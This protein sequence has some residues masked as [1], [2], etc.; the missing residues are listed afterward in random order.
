VWQAVSG[1]FTSYFEQHAPL[2]VIVWLLGVLVLTLRLLG[3]LAYVQRLRHHQ[4]RPVEAEWLQRTQRIAAQIWLVRPV[5]VLESA[6][7][8]VP[9]AIGYFKPLILLPVGTFTGLSPQ[10][11]EAVLAHE[12]AHL[13]RNDYWVNIGQSVVE[14]LFF[15]HPAAWWMSGVVRQEREHCCDDIA[16]QTCGDN[17]TFAQALTRLETLQTAPVLA[18][19]ANGGSLLVRI[20]RLLNQSPQKPGFTDGLLVAGVLLLCLVTVSASAFMNLNQRKSFQHT[21]VSDTADGIETVYAT[22]TDSTKAVREI[23]IVKDT[24]GRITEVR[25]DGKKLNDAEMKKY[26]PVIAQKLKKSKRNSNLAEND[27]EDFADITADAALP[28]L[29]PLPPDPVAGLAPLPPTPPASPFFDGEMDEQMQEL[30]EEMRRLEEKQQKIQEKREQIFEKFNKKHQA[31]IE[32]LM[33]KQQRELED[34]QE[35]ISRQMDKAH[36]EFQKEQE[37]QMQQHE[38]DMALHEEQLKAHE[39]IMEKHEKFMSLV[40][41]ELKKDGILKNE[42]NYRIKIRKNGLYVNDQKQPEQVFQKYKALLKKEIGE[43]I[44]KWGDNQNMEFNSDY[45]SDNGQSRLN[46]KQPLLFDWMQLVYP[47]AVEKADEG[48]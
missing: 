8:R 26:E 25:I 38:K 41:R 1:D 36:E 27:D 9:V 47:N 5:R 29:P 2:L 37:L 20:R 16:V 44:D 43:D 32:E 31:E 45:R 11:A 18:L 14:I 33:E 28:P 24:K 34:Q 46:K 12:L 22:F 30:Q 6:L 17:L 10:Q 23:I 39:K 15:F 35:E 21:L 40:L 13:L 4:T 3:G 19:T 7:V 42:K 48:C